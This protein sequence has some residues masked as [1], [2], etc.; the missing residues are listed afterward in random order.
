MAAVLTEE[1]VNAQNNIKLRP[2]KVALAVDAMRKH[3]VK[4]FADI[5]G[6]WGVHAG[7]TRAA[8]EAVKIQK[9]YVI[10]QFVTGASKKL[11]ARYKQLEFKTALFNQPGFIK[12]FPQVDALIMY[13][14]LLHQVNINWDEFIERWAPKA[15]V[16]I[17][18]NQ[19]WKVGD[20]TTRF[21]D[22]GP[23]WY[24]KWVFYGDEK[25]IDEWLN[26]LDDI[27]PETGR[28]R[29]DL[30]SFWQWGIT[31]HDLI[32]KCEDQ[33]FHLDHF[34]NHGPF[35]NKKRP[36]IQDEAFIFVRNEEH[37]DWPKPV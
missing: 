30:H 11:G 5:G 29:R 22:N 18:F 10:D 3:D 21:L 16:L 15:R 37:S 28:K 12:D 31:T 8:L 4:S 35:H 2:E 6:C 23:D 1:E 34:H 27:D 20:K 13:D 7:Y 17:I 25:R 33:G 32:K 36:W 26:T 9:A 14:I 19:M 24:K